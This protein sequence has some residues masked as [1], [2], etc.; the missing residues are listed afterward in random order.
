MSYN[1]RSE[2]IRLFQF[3][4]W[5]FE[6]LP[7]DKAYLFVYILTSLDSMEVRKQSFIWQLKITTSRC[8]LFNTCNKPIRDTHSRL[9]QSMKKNWAINLY[10]IYLQSILELLQNHRDYILNWIEYNLFS[11]NQL[12]YNKYNF[13]YE[14][15][16]C[17]NK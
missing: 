8:V 7:H 6:E 2:P 13:M 16:S 10:K 5:L 15:E 11:Q 3:C 12:K 17:W 4:I 9:Q 1:W 14:R